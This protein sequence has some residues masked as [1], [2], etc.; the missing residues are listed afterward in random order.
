MQ[1]YYD[2]FYCFNFY[3]TNVRKVSMQKSGEGCYNLYMHLFVQL[4][5]L[6]KCLFQL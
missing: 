3:S 4:L 2:Y 6:E 5:R 1:F